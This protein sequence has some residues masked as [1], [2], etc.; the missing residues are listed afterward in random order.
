MEAGLFAAAFVAFSAASF[1]RSVKGLNTEPLGVV[2]LAQGGLA[3]VLGLIGA[4]LPPLAIAFT[5]LLAIGA[6]Y[7]LVPVVG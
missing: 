3:L 7:G 5:A 4:V 6:W 2:I 1:T